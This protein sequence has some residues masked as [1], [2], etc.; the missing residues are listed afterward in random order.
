M[1]MKR[2]F[3]A[4]L[5]SVL[6][7]CA[8]AQISMRDTSAGSN[9]AI[10]SQLKT[11][12]ITLQYEI[13]KFSTRVIYFDK[14]LPVLGAPNY[15]AISPPTSA[16]NLLHYHANVSH[17]FGYSTWLFSL[18]R[19]L[20]IV[21]YQ[22][23]RLQLISGGQSPPLIAYASP[24][25][26]SSRWPNGHIV[27][28]PLRNLGRP[29]SQSKP[30]E[31]IGSSRIDHFSGHLN[32]IVTKRHPGNV[33]PPNSPSVAPPPTPHPPQADPRVVEFLFATTRKINSN[34]AKS[35]KSIWWRSGKF[36]IRSCIHSDTR[37]S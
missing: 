2:S 21:A 29:H 16:Q 20:K 32:G 24:P 10:V 14:R 27:R 25:N 4:L 1:S 36:I 17:V 22:L 34:S 7:T 9:A 31:D 28:D 13:S 18:D 37:R 26:L 19:N 23:L 33:A 6:A 35:K 8:P 12:I 15:V 11:L 30:M 5:A 3:L